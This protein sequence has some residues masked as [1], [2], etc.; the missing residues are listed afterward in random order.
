ME[1]EPDVDL[2]L[3]DPSRD[4]R[5]DQTIARVAERARVRVRLRR[6]VVR[7]GILAVA[8]AAAA[9]LI[10]WWSAPHRDPATPARGD[11]LDWAVRDVS[12]SDVLELEVTR[13][14]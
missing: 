3:L 9:S 4:P 12:A 11:M 14:R 6:A 1:P 2:S 5:W 13:A 8:L 7:R 10:V